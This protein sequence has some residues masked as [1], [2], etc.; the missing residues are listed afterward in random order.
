MNLWMVLIKYF[1]STFLFM[2]EILDVL[3]VFGLFINLVVMII[4]S[5]WDLVFFYELVSRVAINED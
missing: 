4:D 3:E 5:Y 1:G 2:E